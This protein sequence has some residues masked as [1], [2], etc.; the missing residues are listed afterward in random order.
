[1]RRKILF[2]A[3]ILLVI[4][5]LFGGEQ[6]FP[7]FT[8][9]DLEGNLWSLDSILSFGKPVM[10]TFWA[11]WCKPCRK[12]LDKFV[13]RWDSWDTTRGER[14]YIVV[15]LCE[16]SP[17]SVRR[18]KS[19]AKKQGWTKFLLLH[20]KGGQVKTKAGVAE[21]PE[22]FILAPDGTIFYRHI[23]YN[24]GDEEESFAKLEELLEQL[25][26]KPDSGES[27]GETVP[28]EK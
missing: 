28:V 20:D 25:E 13:E 23:G 27:S 6:K 17:R 1:M 26:Q 7:K 16:D 4:G 8:L 19:L 12:E 18:A 10:L 2:A 5:A 9:E 24:P 11:T 3:A 14:P 15:A 21:I 22:L